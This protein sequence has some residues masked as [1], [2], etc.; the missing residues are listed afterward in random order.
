VRAP[1]GGPILE[2]LGRTTTRDEAIRVVMR[3]MRLVARRLA[4]FAVR[5]DGFDGW[6]CNVAFGDPDALSALHIPADQPSILAT[7]TATAIYL[8]PIPP[9]PAHEGLLQVME[10]A[11]LDVAALAVRVAGRPA[12]VLVCDELDDTMVG[13]RFLIELGYEAGEALERLIGPG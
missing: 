11:S 2:A 10:R 1:D 8:G 4:V 9:T 5:R 13:T 12:M 3:G 7:A 6:A